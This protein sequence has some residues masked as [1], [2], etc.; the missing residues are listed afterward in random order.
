MH[1]SWHKSLSFPRKDYAYMKDRSL[2]FDL[3]RTKIWKDRYKSLVVKFM[4]WSAYAIV[5][6]SVGL[7]AAM[8]TDIEHH[9][10][11]FRREYTDKII[12]GDDG[13]LL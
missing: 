3:L 12:S 10:I 4:E 2:N 11:H 6:L 5:G 7:V 13:F 1:S 9:L 8:M